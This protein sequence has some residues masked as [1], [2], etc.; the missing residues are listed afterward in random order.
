MQ[1]VS[2]HEKYIFSLFVCER[3]RLEGKTMHVLPYH[4]PRWWW[5]PNL[6]YCHKLF[7]SAN[8]NLKCFPPSLPQLCS[9]ITDV[10]S[11]CN[12]LLVFFFLLYL[13]VGL[14]KTTT[15]QTN[16]REDENKIKGR[17]ASYTPI[18]PNESTRKCQHASREVEVFIL[19]RFESK[20]SAK[21]SFGSLDTGK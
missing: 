4:V 7:G 20:P 5:Y 3:D 21:C 8:F 17:M 16:A 1:D 11:P 6:L 10:L 18:Y 14:K 9:S 12:F 15:K 13:N 2:T 19:V